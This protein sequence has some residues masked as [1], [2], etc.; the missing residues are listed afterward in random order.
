MYQ[1]HQAKKKTGAQ[2]T[3][4]QAQLDA[5]NSLIPFGKNNLQKGD[6]A[7][8]QALNFYKGVAA[9]PRQAMASELNERAASDRMTMRSVGGMAPRGGASADVLS[10]LPWMRA[11]QTTNALFGAR[12]NANSQIATIGANRTNAGI[13][14][15]SGGA[16]TGGALLNYGLNRNQQA[17]DQGSQAGSSTY[18]LAQGIL[19]AWAKRSSDG[20]GTDWAS[21]IG[22]GGSGSVTSM[23]GGA[24]AWGLA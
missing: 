11:G 15:L 6:Q 16:G 9:D 17:F 18:Q 19:N 12:N 23:P 14:A 13:S 20:K 5:M 4:E 10:R 7:T 24:G 22:G 8:D 3:A 1:S 21:G 2:K